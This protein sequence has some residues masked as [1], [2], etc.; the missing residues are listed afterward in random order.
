MCMLTRIVGSMLTVIGLYGF[1][2][3]KKKEMERIKEEKAFNNNSKK[4]QLTK[5]DL[6]L[7]FSEKSFTSA[8]SKI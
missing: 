6:E 2:W 8:Q 7:Q 1:L 3:G 4:Q 5:I